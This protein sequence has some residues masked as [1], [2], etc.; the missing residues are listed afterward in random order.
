MGLVKSRYIGR[1]FIE[2]SPSLREQGVKLKLSA[3]RGVVEGKR[4]AL[5][6]DSFV[7]GTTGKRITRLLKE[8]G[9]REVHLLISS[10]PIRYPCFYGID[11]LST[12]ELLAA[13]YDLAELT[14]LVGADSLH[15][16]SVAGMRKVLGGGLCLACFTGEYP[17]EVPEKF[18]EGKRWQMLTA[19]RE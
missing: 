3:V 15:F 16:L 9:A 6:D 5:V 19:G 4:V 11:T 7:R 1:T 14:A 10:P 12:E 13:H 18:E 17:T 2:P 8:A